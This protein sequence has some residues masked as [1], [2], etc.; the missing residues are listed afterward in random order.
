MTAAQVEHQPRERAVPC[1]RCRKVETWNVTAICQFCTEKLA[2]RECRTC[3]GDRIVEEPT[4]GRLAAEA[5]RVIRCPK[6]RD[7][8]P[9]RATS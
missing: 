1:T 8:K 4:Y 7:G 5:T 3:K 6:C 9:I 2:K